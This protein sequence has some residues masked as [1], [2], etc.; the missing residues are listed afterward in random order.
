MKREQKERLAL[1]A[2]GPNLYGRSRA[3]G[4]EP[5]SWVYV[6]GAVKNPDGIPDPLTPKGGC[7]ICGSAWV[8]VRAVGFEVPLHVVGAVSEST[9]WVKTMISMPVSAV[10]LGCA[11]GHVVDYD[12]REFVAAPLGPAAAKIV[13]G[14][15]LLAM[16]LGLF[17]KFGRKK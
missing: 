13:A 17:G 7:P 2:T 1:A 5:T 4:R 11:E 14:G 3:S 10:R 9:W 8:D 6:F 15:L 12:G 16:S